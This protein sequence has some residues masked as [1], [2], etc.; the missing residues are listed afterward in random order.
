MKEIGD[1]I[2]NYTR[3][4][5]IY[6]NYPRPSEFMVTPQMSRGRHSVISKVYSSSYNLWPCPY[7][8]KSFS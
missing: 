5:G 7:Y 8:C 2:H 4:T 1:A 3:A 6:G